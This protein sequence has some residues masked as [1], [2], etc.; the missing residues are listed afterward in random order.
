[1]KHWQARY[2]TNPVQ[3]GASMPHLPEFSLSLMELNSK[4]G[5]PGHQPEGKHG[6]DGGEHPAV[7]DTVLAVQI[8]VHNQR[9]D[10]HG[11]EIRDIHKRQH[12]EGRKGAHQ[13]ENEAG[14]AD[15]GRKYGIELKCSSFHFLTLLAQP[16]V[17]FTAT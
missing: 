12:R 3:S 8:A 16:T 4:A 13:H 15:H 9:G 11:G 10:G 14:E 17:M 1:M 2:R 6:Q 7:G 5:G